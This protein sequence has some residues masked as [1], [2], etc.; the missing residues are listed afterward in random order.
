M[1]LVA[2]HEADSTIHM[3]TFPFG[4]FTHLMVRIAIAVTLLIGFVHH[5][6]A[7]AVAELVEVFTVGI[8]RG[9]QEVDVRLLHQCDVLFVGGIIDITTC[10]WMV[11]VTVHTTQFHVLPVNFEDLTHTFHTLHT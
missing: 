1:V 7:I 5:V 2:L 10:H 4:V 3:G 11:V 8:M 9:A 6:D